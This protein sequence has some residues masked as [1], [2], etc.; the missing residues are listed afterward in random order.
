MEIRKCRN[1]LTH[2][3]IKA[4][5]VDKPLAWVIT[6]DLI[7]DKMNFY[8]SS[9]SEFR[10]YTYDDIKDARDQARELLSRDILN[11]IPKSRGSKIWEPLCFRVFYDIS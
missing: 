5:I 7:L 4:R 6:G 10:L 2:S 9:I 1:S 3:T 8:K 11:I